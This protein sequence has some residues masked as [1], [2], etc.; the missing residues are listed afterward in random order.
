MD[1]HRTRVLHTDYNESLAATI[2][3][4]LSSPMFRELVPMPSISSAS[5]HLPQG[6]DEENLDCYSP[7]PEQDED[8]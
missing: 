2:E 1:T 3:L 7:P 4:S 5:S 6:V 8:L